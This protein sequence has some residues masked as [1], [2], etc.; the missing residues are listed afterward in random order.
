MVYWDWEVTWGDTSVLPSPSVTGLGLGLLIPGVY[1][2]CPPLLPRFSIKEAG[3]LYKVRFSEV[4]SRETPG[5]T[6]KGKMA[7]T[8]L[9]LRF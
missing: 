4:R 7:T 9:V 2:I 3:T 8:G 6:F 5:K 1:R